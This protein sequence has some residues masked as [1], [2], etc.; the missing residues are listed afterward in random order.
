M[1]NSEQ[2][3]TRGIKLIL[4]KPSTTLDGDGKA[5]ILID[6]IEKAIKPKAMEVIL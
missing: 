3:Q 5:T 1:E 4:K 2:I 6:F